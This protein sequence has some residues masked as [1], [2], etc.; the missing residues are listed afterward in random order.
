VAVVT[1]GRSLGHARGPRIG[2][3][4]DRGQKVNFAGFLDPDRSDLN[5][6]F[7]VDRHVDA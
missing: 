4:A 1:R 3:R 5:S 6:H 2:G 7:A